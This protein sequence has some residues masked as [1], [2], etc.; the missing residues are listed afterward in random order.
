MVNL[1]KDERAAD[2]E[3]FVKWNKKELQKYA[4]QTTPSEVG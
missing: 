3:K 4:E 1:R 2:I